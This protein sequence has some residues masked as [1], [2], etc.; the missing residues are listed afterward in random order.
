MPELLILFTRYAVPGRAKSRLV[1]ALGPEGAAAWQREMT[2]RTAARARAAAGGRG[3]HLWVLHQGG[4]PGAMA[5]W[6]GPDLVCLPQAGG[7]LG[8]RMEAAFAAAFARG[9]DRV[10]LFGSDIPGLGERILGRS[11][12][13]L[14]ERDL[15]LGP[16]R[17]GGYYL[18]GLT[19]PH[20]ELFRGMKWSTERVLAQTL[21]RAR[22]L[23]LVLLEELADVDR[24]EDLA[25]WRRRYRQGPGKISVVIPALNEE[26]NIGTALDSLA[27]EAVLEVL[28]VDGGSAD[29]TAELACSRGARVVAH[30]PGRA[31]QQN[32]GAA[33]ARGETLLFLHADTVLPPGFGGIVRQTLARPR[34]SAGA[35]SLSLGGSRPGLRLIQGLANFRSR[36]LGMPYG[37]QGLFLSA[38]AF[39]RSGGF[40]DQPLMEDFEL[41]RRLGRRGRVR[42]A[43]Q[44]AISSARRWLKLGLLRT[45]LLNQLIILGYY[46]KI[47]PATLARLYARKRGL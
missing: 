2:A 35:F 36:V 46:L 6:L 24:P 9:Y 28:V 25:G 12:D 18:I 40:P 5:R 16:A 10:V 15:V 3:A 43:P 22:G 8:A 20:P 23:S 37:D 45:T 42:T 32:R 17:D 33:L 29:R 41:V 7:D 4:G 39:W 38:D 26:K 47:S 27:D 1:P 13:L 21:E 34:T 11:L 14:R 44:R 19:R 30:P 31:G